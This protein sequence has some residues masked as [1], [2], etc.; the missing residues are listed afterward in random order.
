MSQR[1]R[2]SFSETPFFQCR[3]LSGGRIVTARVGVPPE[4]SLREVVVTP[5]V[6]GGPLGNRPAGRLC[7]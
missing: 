6:T 3:V 4:R 5:E 7:R 1:P 2:T